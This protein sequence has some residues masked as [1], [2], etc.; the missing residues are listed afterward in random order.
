M[1]AVMLACI[2]K[3]IVFAPPILALTVSGCALTHH[4]PKIQFPESG[5][6]VLHFQDSP[7]AARGLP[8]IEASINGVR[9]V[10]IIDTGA[11]APYLTMTTARRCHLSLADAKTKN[12]DMYYA[13][14]V[15]M[16]VAEDV[17]IVVAPGLS[18]RWSKAVV[19]PR[20]DSYFGLLD[21]HTLRAM[22]AVIDMDAKTITISR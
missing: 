20:D 4:H 18:I 3:L 6:A 17:T 14:S 12:I 2:K 9:G 13:Q 7:L 11:N 19:D 5:R 15:P 21:Y 10:F 8:Y 22:H 1:L 16:K